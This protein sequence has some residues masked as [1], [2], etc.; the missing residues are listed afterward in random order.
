MSGLLLTTLAYE[1]QPM[2]LDESQSYTTDFLWQEIIYKQPMHI[3]DFLL[4]TSLLQELSPTIC[5]ELTGRTDSAVL[6]EKL[7]SDGLFI[8]KLQSTSLTYRYHH[9]FTKALQDELGKRYEVDIIAKIAKKAAFLYFEKG[10]L[11]TAIELAM[12]YKLFDVATKWINEHY[13]IILSSKQ[14]GMFIRWIQRLRKEDILL[15]Y[16]ILIFGLMNAIS[17]LQ[18]EL[19]HD[20][21]NELEALQL[22]EQWMDDPQYADLTNLFIRTKA[23]YLVGL[24]DKLP[25]V[26]SLL[27]TQL[28]KKAISSKKEGI[29]ISYNNYEVNLLRMGLASKGKLIPIEEAGNV[30]QLFRHTELNQLAVAPYI[31]AVGTAMLYELNE[32]PEAEKELAI[33]LEIAHQK[34]TPELYVPLYLIKA[35]IYIMQELP[36]SAL[37]MLQQVEEKV[38]E[39]HWKNALK[40]MQ[41]YC[42][43]LHG[44]LEHAQCLLDDTKSYLPYWRLTYARFL[45]QN[46]QNEDALHTIVQVKT[47]AQQETQLAT[48]VEASV[49]EVICHSQMNNHTNAYKSLHEAFQLA[50]PYGYIRT[51]LDEKK[52]IPLIQRYLKEPAY[53][54]TWESTS[55]TYFSVLKKHMPTVYV[56]KQVKITLTPREKDIFKLIIAGAKN[57]EIA[58]QLHLSEGT[59]R[60][61]L[62]ALYSKLGVTSRVEA[63]L[64]AQSHPSIL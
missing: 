48:T 20:L 25:E 53:V 44:E 51:F 12:R 18:F 58:T 23:Y 42:H 52:V 13:E 26:L 29:D 41:A 22:K 38:S 35:K 33:S 3:Q 19:A 27:Q 50:I 31:F 62:T 2:L 6:L 5:D 54:E 36:L 28:F 56:N 37:A 32:I 21:M 61:Y 34:D 4:R 63:I 47:E 57:R 40:I 55:Q 16:E 60:V 15:S 49:L 45:L 59:V 10:E 9:L 8:F 7:E 43:I 39:K 1:N 11:L 64:Y 30:I 14:T 24:G 17:S 46:G